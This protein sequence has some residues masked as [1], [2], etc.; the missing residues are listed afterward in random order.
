MELSCRCLGCGMGLFFEG[1]SVG[2]GEGDETRG[3]AF[4]A[5]L[6]ASEMTEEADEEGAR[7]KIKALIAFQ[8]YGS[9][10]EIGAIPVTCESCEVCFICTLYSIDFRTRGC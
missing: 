5:E 9:E 3:A 4:D 6:E 2:D 10:S 8:I 7:I 1:V